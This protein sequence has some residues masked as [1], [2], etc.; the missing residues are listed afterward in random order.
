MLAIKNS[1]RL[2]LKKIILFLISNCRVS[3]QVEVCG[4]VALRGE[5]NILL[6]S[7]ATRGVTARGGTPCGA[8]L[9]SFAAV[10]KFENADEAKDRRRKEEHKSTSRPKV[11]Q[12]KKNKKIYK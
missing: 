9:E 7:E 4:Y 1:R 3:F 10:Q 2:A 11:A 12:R 5:G 8:F 6:K